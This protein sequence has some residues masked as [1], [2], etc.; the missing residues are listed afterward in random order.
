MPCPSKQN[1]RGGS[2]ARVA[3]VSSPRDERGNGH[4]SDHGQ[5][6]LSYGRSYTVDNLNCEGAEDG[7]D[8]S[9]EE[10]ETDVVA[11]DIDLRMLNIQ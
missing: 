4:E 11:A 6:A 5:A 3:P 7:A 2:F 1:R 10:G 9:L 8:S